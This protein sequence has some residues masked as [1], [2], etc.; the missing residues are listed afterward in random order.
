MV[1]WNRSRPSAVACPQLGYWTLWKSQGRVVWHHCVDASSKT[2]WKFCRI[3]RTLNTWV[4]RR[5]YHRTRELVNVFQLTW[6]ACRLRRP[7]RDLLFFLRPLTLVSQFSRQSSKWQDF[8]FATP[9]SLDFVYT[10]WSL[11][12]DCAYW[13]VISWTQWYNPYWPTDA[14][15][16]SVGAQ[17][18]T[19]LYQW[20]TSLTTWCS[21]CPWSGHW[22]Q[23][24]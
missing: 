18:Q 20:S 11:L 22:S 12:S 24:R 1:D 19:W 10:R 3:S 21:E 17:K 14:S 6:K 5:L 8:Y 13:T 9:W 23:S 16:V 4:L 15:T 2:F 7:S